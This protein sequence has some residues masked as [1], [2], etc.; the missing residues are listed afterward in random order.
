MLHL[1]VR[2]LDVLRGIGALAIPGPL[3]HKLGLQLAFQH[4]CDV[5]AQH[6]E[7]LVSVE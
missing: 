4:L 5:L 2:I 3:L 6:G 1:R 7:E